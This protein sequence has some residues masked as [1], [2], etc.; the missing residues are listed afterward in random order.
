MLMM[1]NICRILNTLTLVTVIAIVPFTEAYASRPKS[2]ECMPRIPCTHE[3][4]FHL[5]QTAMCHDDILQQKATDE[6][7]Q[8]FR[9]AE[10][11]RD[12]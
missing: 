9:G 2:C 7:K 11:R 3:S 4:G 5:M 8:Q 6:S 10:F 1:H 12:D